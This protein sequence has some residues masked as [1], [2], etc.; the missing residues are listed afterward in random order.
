MKEGSLT[1][2]VV[3]SKWLLACTLALHLLA[4]LAVFIA[5]LAWLARFAVLLALGVSVVW[6][7]WLRRS[8]NLRCEM[9]GTLLVCKGDGWK[10]AALLPGAV[11]SPL[12]IVLR[13]RMESRRV[14]QSFII[15]TDSLEAEDFRRLRVWLRWKAKS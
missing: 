4:G 13:I 10:A 14:A 11:V 6:I 9:D 5:D 3:P 8:I 15:L 12:M 7:L 1:L 2:T